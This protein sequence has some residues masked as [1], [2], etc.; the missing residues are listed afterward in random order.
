MLAFDIPL[1]DY[2]KPVIDKSGY[3]AVIDTGAG[4]PVFYLPE[5]IMKNEFSGIK[6]GNTSMSGSTGESITVP[7]YRI[8]HFSIGNYV[9][10]NIPVQVCTDEAV[11]ETVGYDILLGS[12]LFADSCLKIDYANRRVSCEMKEMI[13][14]AGQLW[15]FCNGSWKIL[16]YVPNVGW[17]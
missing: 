5:D 6:I 15:T 16:N 12:C 14:S 1:L 3:T 17:T 10:K 13:F 11:A 7:I 8:K 9:L 2:T 4:V